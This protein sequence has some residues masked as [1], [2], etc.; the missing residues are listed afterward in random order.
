MNTTA[1][2]A[3][4]AI[5]AGLEIYRQHANKP[6]GWVPSAEDWNELEAWAQRTPEDIKREA[7]ER[8]GG[9]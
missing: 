4:Q 1:I 8:R 6:P 2:L 5:V 7:R 9:N 3:A